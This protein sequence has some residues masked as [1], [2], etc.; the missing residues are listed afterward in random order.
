MKLL[1]QRVSAFLLHVIDAPETAPETREAAQELDVDI[2][3]AINGNYRE[4]DDNA[5]ESAD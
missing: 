3:D 4:A 1:L 2:V 5:D